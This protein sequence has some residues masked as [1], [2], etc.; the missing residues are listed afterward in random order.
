MPIL[1]VGADHPVGFA[2][3][4]RLVHPEREVRGFV[5]DP[6]VG[7]QLKALGAKVAVGDLSDEGHIAAAATRCFSIAFIAE[8][9]HDGREL[10][11]LPADQLPAAW[12]RAAVEGGVTRVIWVGVSPP[13]FRIPEVAV[14][15][16]ESLSDEEIVDEVVRLDDLAT[17]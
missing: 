12:A 9:A 1:V 6:T 14:V 15:D 10:A 2:T 13:E 11:F 17:L 16:R 4:A 7:A 8:A 5:T 3:V